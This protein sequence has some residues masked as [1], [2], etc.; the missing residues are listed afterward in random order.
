M[1]LARFAALLFIPL[2]AAACVVENEHS[3]V[4]EELKPDDRLNGVWAF[5]S[6]GHV[7]LLIMSR[8]N[9]DSTELGVRLIG[10]DRREH[11]VSTF[12]LKFTEI[13][14]RKYFEA[15]GIRGEAPFMPPVKR[16]FGTW[17]I[18]DTGGSRTLT[19]CPAGPENFLEV[20]KNKTL[21]GYVGEDSPR[22]LIVSSSTDATRAFLEKNPVK[23]EREM[24]QVYRRLS[25]PERKR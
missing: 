1:K 13:G 12:N 2:F 19:L 15:Y 17:E 14:G 5:E 7:T 9:E 16:F 3:I 21:P 22:R 4:T 24:T 8:D 20:L 10:G 25:G 6:S 23:C 18:S 11:I